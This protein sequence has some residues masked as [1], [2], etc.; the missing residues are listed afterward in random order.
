MTDM[1]QTRITAEEY[2]Q[3]PEHAELDLIQLIDGQVVIGKTPFIK[4]QMILANVLF[5]LVIHSRQAGGEALM[6]PTEV[7]IDTYNV[8]EPDVFYMPPDSSCTRDEL[9]IYGAPEL[10]IEILSPSTARRDRTTKYSAYEQHGV[11][12]YWIVDPAHETVEVYTQGDSGFERVGV[13]G[14]D[15]SFDSGVLAESISAAA[16]FDV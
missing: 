9:R 13:F 15:D 7:Y 11:Q 10:V 12:E 16:I 3:L 2:F 1:T 5:I 8:Y 4:H 14:D 6:L